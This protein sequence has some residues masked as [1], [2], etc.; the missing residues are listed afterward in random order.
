[1]EDLEFCLGIPETGARKEVIGALAQVGWH[2]VGEGRE[3]HHLLRTVR[4]VQPCLT[5]IDLAL[6]GEVL[7]TAALIEEEAL[8]AVL[9]LA[10]PGMEIYRG[11]P[12][13]ELSFVLLRFPLDRV[14]LT[15]AAEVLSLAFKRQKKLHQE[16]GRLKE[17]LRTRV[18]VERAKGAVMKK[19][20]LDEQEAYRYLQKRSMDLRLPMKKV[21][22]AVFQKGRHD[23]LD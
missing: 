18:A 20:A 22:E 6:P 11:T 17:K 3:C 7:S 19:Y 9:L 14:A 12:L 5:V 23:I 21:A 4:Q 16:L 2:A 10:Q 1:M 15:T 13:S 8:S